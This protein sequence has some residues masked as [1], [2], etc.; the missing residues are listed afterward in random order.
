MKYVIGLDL[1]TTSVGWAVVDGENKKIVDLGV[2]IF[3]SAENPKNGKSLAEPRRIARS[4]RRRIARR[5]SRLDKVKSIFIENGLLT[6]EDIKR[7][8][9]N[10]NNPYQ[11]RYEALDRILSSEELFV[12]LYHLAKRRGYKSNRKKV[13][14]ND[15]SE[16]RAVLS[17]IQ[18]NKKLLKEKNCRTVGEMF[19]KQLLENKSNLSF[20][21][22][23]N[24]PGSY[25]YSVSREMLEE[26]LLLILNSQKSIGSE[27]VTDD[28][29]N[30]FVKYNEHNDP[31]GAFNFQRHY[32]QGERLKEMVGICTF[33][34]KKNGFA[35]DEMRAAKSTYTFQYFNFLQ[36]LNH[37]TIGGMHFTDEEHKLLIEKAL[38]TKSIKYGQIRSWLNIP[39]DKRFNIVYALSRKEVDGKTMEEIEVLKNEFEKKQKFP[40]LSS[41]YEIKKV[42]FD[43]DN[44]FWQK[45]EN[46]IEIIDS[47]AE[48]L[49][50]YKTDKDIKERLAEIELDGNKNIFP[51]I[52]VSGLMGLSFTKFGHLS[53]KALRKIIPFL[54]QGMTYDKAVTAADERYGKNLRTRTQKLQPIDKDDY[55]ITNPVVRRTVSQTIK[56][57]NAII[58]KYGSPDEVHIEL[59]RDLS[60]RK[61]E[62]NKL[63]KSQSENRQRNEVALE[64]I[65]SKGIIDPSGKDIVRYKL[66][67]EQ[68]CKCAYSGKPIDENRLFE[69]GYTQ[70]DHI[71]PFS[72][73]FDDSYNNKV[74]VLTS[75]NQE[76]LNKLPYEAFGHNEDRWQ[77]FENLIS[78]MNLP[79][80]KKNNLLL[81]KYVMEELTARTL[82]DTRFLAKY[83]KNYIEN[84][85]L[86][87][88]GDKKKRVITVNG[89]ATA[90]L[91]SRWGLNKNRNE[92]DIHHAQDAA[93]VAVTNGSLINKVALDAKLGEVRKAFKRNPKAVLPDTE[94]DI[95]AE[96]IEKA[97]KNVRFPEPWQGFSHDLD[98]ELKNVFVSRMPRRKVSGKV[99]DDTLRSPKLFDEEKSSV[100]KP[101]TSVTEKM[102]LENRS[103]IDPGIYDR[104]FKKLRE[105]GGDAKKAFAEPFY[106]IQKDGTNGP[107]V[108]TL[109]ITEGGQKSGIKINNGN[110][111]VDRAS[112]I[113]VDLFSK[114]NTKGK[115]EFYFIPIY[116]HHTT[117][118]KLP[119]RVVTVGKKESEW[120]QI[121][122]LFDFKFSLYPGDLISVVKGGEEKYWYYVKAGI[123]TASLTVEAH[124]R[125]G[126]I[127]SMGIKTLDKVDKYVV[128]VLGNY[129]L[130]KKEKRSGFKK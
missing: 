19:Y 21:G 36:K 113:R 92:T 63:V 10:P 117:Q 62:R 54:E 114:K 116:A 52:V 74:L 12:S 98:G 28:F 38:T 111:L 46:N 6:K 42:I 81:K 33:Q 7:I 50:L 99:H 95:S 80:R 58:D 18:E 96:D 105:N 115:D 57:V 118:K 128:D 103:N 60:K 70:I 3:E 23:R 1:G 109:K 24:K 79:Y 127:P 84:T 76:K 22:V 101:L 11:L 110:S 90:Y 83:L 67:S 15:D 89:A 75:E 69:D 123:S 8:H 55:S 91:R 64:N 77:K 59:G 125:S 17:S 47:V 53:L 45:I 26:E 72:R 49:T 29:I 56:V 16:G 112:M 34:N 32:A 78:T 65:K 93:V 87:A 25:K 124:D 97:K 14:E 94:A 40:D 86:F 2:R 130:V 31:V 121:D 119:N 68:D 107:I 9:N 85:L 13:L 48:V 82:N 44:Y 88:E 71:V 43:N 35:E 104:L 41:Y 102:L 61:D 120:Q 66:W 30:K 27:I 129:H 4:M 108:R 126:S 5:S 51:E 106:K 122:E 73:S 37:T 100:R 39:E 20:S